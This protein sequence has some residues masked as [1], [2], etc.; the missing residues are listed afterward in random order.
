MT[1]VKIIGE[2]IAVLSSV[3]CLHMDSHETPGY[4]DG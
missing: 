3:Y 1:K 4:I 2:R